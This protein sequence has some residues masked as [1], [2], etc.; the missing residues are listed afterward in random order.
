MREIHDSKNDVVVVV[1]SRALINEYFINISNQINDKT[2]NILTFID[3]INTSIAKRNIF[4]VTPERCR[5]L[6]KQKENFEVDL[7]LF[8]EAQLSNE[9]SKRGL[10]YDSIIRRCQKA[11]PKAKF[12]FA[13]PFVKNPISQID[14]NHF[15]PQTSNA[16]SYNQKNVGQVFMQIDEQGKFY[17]FGIDQQIMGKNRVLCPFDPIQ[18]KR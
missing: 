13:H 6:F 12:V 4:V 3:N 5:E 7:F 15:N 9:N 10:F 2:I 8:D 14:K 16:I 11:Y 1:P 17:H 18:K